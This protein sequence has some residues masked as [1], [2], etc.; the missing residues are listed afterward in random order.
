MFYFSLTYWFLPGR[1]WLVSCDWLHCDVIVFVFGKYL[2]IDCFDP[3]H[4]GSCGNSWYGGCQ[5][6][7]FTE[8]RLYSVLIS[9]Y[10]TR[11]PFHKEFMNSNMTC[12]KVWP[13]STI[14]I[15][16]AAKM[17]LA[18]IQL[19]NDNHEPFIKWVPVSLLQ[20]VVMDQNLTNNRIAVIKY[21]SL[22]IYFSSGLNI[23]H[24][25]TGLGQIKLP[26]R[27]VDFVAFYIVNK[28]RV[29][30]HGHQGWNVRLGLC[31]I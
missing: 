5:G 18:R 4:H 9:V 20:W 21:I 14:R 23:S 6:F 2:M 11:V 28:Q 13:D 19:W 15:K 10:K 30:M 7:Q 29:L 27:P 31:H 22:S 12:T 3:N 17:I 24:C 25:L 1:Y 16:T 26:V 8:H